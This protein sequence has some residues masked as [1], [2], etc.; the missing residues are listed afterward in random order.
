[1][2][3][4]AFEP[5]IE[6]SEPAQIHALGHVATGIGL[7]LTINSDYYPKYNRLLFNMGMH[8]VLCEVETESSYTSTQ[9]QFSNV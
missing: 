1:M 5:A 3:P 8:G 7:I 2:L 9:H 6:A 4:A